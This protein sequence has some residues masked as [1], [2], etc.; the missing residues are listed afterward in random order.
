MSPRDLVTL[1]V[2]GGIAMVIP[3]TNVR[4]F[5]P[6]RRRSRGD[7]VAWRRSVVTGDDEVGEIVGT[8]G[9]V[10]VT[11]R[12]ILRIRKSRTSDA[13]VYWC[14]VGTD[15]ANVTLKFHSLDDALA[16]AHQRLQLFAVDGHHDVRYLL[17][18]FSVNRRKDVGI[19]III[20][21][22]KIISVTEITKLLLG[23]Q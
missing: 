2:G 5:C 17:D 11:G 7:A 19:I 23:P 20:I 13:G 16:L 9:R 15:R 4:I 3:A 6:V 18:R 10:K 21:I 1:E 8:H 12:G 14:I 22:I